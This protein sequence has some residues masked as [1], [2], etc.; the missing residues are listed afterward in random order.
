MLMINLFHLARRARKKRTK[1]DQFEVVMDGVVQQLVEAQDR[2]EQR[3]MQMEEK[4]MQMEERLM[5]KE[6]ALQHQYQQ[7]QLKMMEMM[8]NIVSTHHSSQSLHPPMSTSTQYPHYY[9]PVPYDYQV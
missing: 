1:G 4:R 6:I 2:A 5:E 3:Y 9:S 8:N 7:F